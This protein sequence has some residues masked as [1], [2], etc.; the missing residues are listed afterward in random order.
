[1]HGRRLITRVDYWRSEGVVLALWTALVIRVGLNYLLTRHYGL[2]DSQIMIVVLLTAAIFLSGSLLRRIH[3]G[4]VLGPLSIV[5]W[6]VIAVTLLY[7]QWWWFNLATRE[8]HAPLWQLIAV[9]LLLLGSVVLRF[10]ARRQTLAAAGRRG[11][12]WILEWADERPVFQRLTARRVL[13]M[14]GYRETDNS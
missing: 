14:L 13:A 8:Y 3:E 2:F 1:M 10:L 12:R 7:N 9:A 5:G 4:F 11:H 6:L